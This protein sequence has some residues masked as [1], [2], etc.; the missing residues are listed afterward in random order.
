M[1]QV[2]HNCQNADYTDMKSKIIPMY[3]YSVDILIYS[4]PSG[5]LVLKES[6]T[7]FT[8]VLVTL[9]LLQSPLIIMNRLNAICSWTKWENILSLGFRWRTDDGWLG[10]FAIFQGIRTSYA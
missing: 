4:G 9:E 6:R 10:S 2:R 7:P 8:L 3:R 1:N 5:I